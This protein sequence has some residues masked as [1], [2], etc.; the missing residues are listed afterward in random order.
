QA[1]APTGGSP[2]DVLGGGLLNEGTA[3]VT[4]CLFAGNQA[5]GGLPQDATDQLG[6]SGGG[7]LDNSGG[8]LTLTRSRFLGNRALSAAGIAFVLGGGLDNNSGVHGDAPATATVTDCLFLGNVATGGDGAA[9]NGG[10]VCNV[11]ATMTLT[12]CTVAGNRS[13]GG[14]N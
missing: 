14:A 7:G 2:Q 12:G 9:G 4:S 3:T 13:I 5:L 10:G 8:T 6:G 11:G 1:V